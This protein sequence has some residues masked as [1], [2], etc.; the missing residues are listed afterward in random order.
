MTPHH[1]LCSKRCHTGSKWLVLRREGNLGLAE[2]EIMEQPV[3]L[4]PQQEAELLNSTVGFRHAVRGGRPPL[5][6]GLPLAI[7]TPSTQLVD[8]TA[9]MRMPHPR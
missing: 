9:G 2:G 8:R 4:G 7:M 6:E 1:L 3:Q 5:G